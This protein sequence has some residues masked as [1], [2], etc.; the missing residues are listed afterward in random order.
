MKI[1]WWKPQPPRRKDY[2]ALAIASLF[3]VLINLAIGRYLAAALWAFGSAASFLQ[4]YRLRNTANI[5]APD[6]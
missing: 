4:V 1:P 6:A 3:V 2:A 5:D